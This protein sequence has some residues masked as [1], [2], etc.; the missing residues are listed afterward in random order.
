MG[1]FVAHLAVV[2][3]IARLR[4]GR[5]PARPPAPAQN[6]SVAEAVEID[7]RSGQKIVHREFRVTTKLAERDAALRG[8][9]RAPAR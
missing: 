9:G 1:V 8:T 5:L 6:F 4:S 7:P 3:I 2:M